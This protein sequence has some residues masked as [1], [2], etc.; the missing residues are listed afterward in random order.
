LNLA[1]QNIR[2]E[3]NLLRA[4][5]E[6]QL[7]RAYVVTYGHLVPGFNNQKFFWY[8]E[9]M[10]NVLLKNGFSKAI[11]QKDYNKFIGLA[12]EASKELYDPS[13]GSEGEYF[14]QDKF[15]REHGLGSCSK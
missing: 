6:M 8:I 7:A 12:N 2:V 10:N 5:W 9:Q 15:D 13:A 14:D 4:M 3:D 1:K 11:S